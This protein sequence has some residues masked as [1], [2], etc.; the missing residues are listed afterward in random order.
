[1]STEKWFKDLLES[2]EGDFEF[3]LE[4]TILNIT[5]QI[6]KKMK[7]K[8]INRSRLAGILNVSPAAVTK[9]LNGNSNFTLRTLLSLSD[10][11]DSELTVQIRDNVQSTDSPVL[12][13]M[14]LT[15]ASNERIESAYANHTEAGA[16]PQA[17]IINA[18]QNLA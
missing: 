8:D 5:E 9:I 4:T 18:Q 6:C 17:Y 7:E 11:L 1:M 13:T 15:T 16:I 10:A 14:E 2:F 12:T 3:R